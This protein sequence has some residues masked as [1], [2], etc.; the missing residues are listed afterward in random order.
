VT[1]VRRRPR[2]GGGDLLREEILAA[3]EQLLLDIGS[4]DAG[5]LHPDLDAFTTALHVSA[6]I[7]GLTSLPVARPT[8]PWPDHE[9]LVE[10][11]LGLCI[12]PHLAPAPAR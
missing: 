6:D 10:R 5:R 2:R 11:R 12:A 9:E 4:D 3:P 8:L 1:T 7:H